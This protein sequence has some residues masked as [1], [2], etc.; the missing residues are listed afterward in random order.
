MRL[1]STPR[2]NQ[3]HVIIWGGIP[4][5]HIDRL[6]NV[7]KRVRKSGL[8]QNKSNCVLLYKHRIS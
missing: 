6:N 7:M 8:K 4:R 1:R 2:D 3:N 5:K